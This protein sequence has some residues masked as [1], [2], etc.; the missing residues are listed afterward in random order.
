[1]ENN[2]LASSKHVCVVL[3]FLISHFVTIN[4]W[5]YKWNPNSYSSVQDGQ[6][7]IMYF[8]GKLHEN[9]Y[10]KVIHSEDDWM[11][12][13]ARNVVHNISLA[14]LKQF[15]E[16][17]WP[18]DESDINVCIRKQKPKEECQ[19]YIRVLVPKNTMDLFVCGTNAF[20]PRCRTY[21]KNSE[22]KYEFKGKEEEGIAKCPFDPKQNS[23]SIYVDGKFYSATVADFSARDPLILE[24]DKFIRSEQYD[25][26]WLNEPNFVSSFA[27]EDKVFFFF[28]ETAIENINCGKATFS[29]VARICKQDQ[30]GNVLLP[31]TWTSF[32]K[33]RLNCSIPGN[34]PFY[35]NEIQST[36]SLEEGSYRPVPNSRD[37]H[38]MIYGVFTTS[39]NSIPGSAIC[40]FSHE[41]IINTFQGQ[42]KGQESALHNWLAVPE[43]KVPVPHPQEC[44]RHS[45]DLPDMTL[46][47][48]KTHPLMD[49][50]V[51]ARGGAPILVHT[52]FTS[53]FTQIAVDWQVN[54]G[55]GRYYDIIFVGTNDGRVIK[56]INKG[57]TSKIETVIIEDILVFHDHS[58]ITNLKVYKKNSLTEKLVVMSSKDIVSIPLHRCH[59]K[60]SCH[61]CVALQDPYCSWIENKCA[62]SERGIQNIQEGKDDDCGPAPPMGV[63]KPP[64]T[65]IR[66]FVPQKPLVCN[67]KDQEN[68]QKTYPIDVPNS[69]PVNYPE[70]PEEN[71]NFI[72]KGGR[73]EEIKDRT[74]SNVTASTMAISVV[75]SIVLSLVIGFLIGY[76]VSSC[77]GSRNIDTPHLDRN[78]AIQKTKNRLSSTGENVYFNPE[79]VNLQKPNINYVVNVTNQGKLNSS[80][81][82]KPVHKSNKVYL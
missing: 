41:D 54:S 26:K 46:D 6:K 75:V 71:Q 63:S 72:D 19:N 39:E 58:P 48:I 67:C 73:V 35:F 25:S 27:K 49:K 9:D 61:A 70:M 76:K 80:V 20:R 37:R 18:A 36:T 11:L 4:S 30:G 33:A 5:Q 81:E 13:G 43:E 16:I 32:F 64:T 28:R 29:R 52:S 47:F 21:R 53:R 50:A 56:T 17:K 45:K 60:M 51:P 79:T 40:A 62:N 42:F 38:D 3:I 66:H 65:T 24:S 12:V 22:G 82:T 34:M 23:T 15:D 69:V 59:E 44:S 74:E 78:I 2:Y 31:N 77:R 68:P 14:D 8:H 55:K 57:E 1:M 10:F 7:S